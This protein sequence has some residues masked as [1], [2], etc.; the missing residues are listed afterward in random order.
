MKIQVCKPA[1]LAAVIRAILGVYTP[2]IIKH[3]NGEVRFI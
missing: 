2:A 1:A 3:P